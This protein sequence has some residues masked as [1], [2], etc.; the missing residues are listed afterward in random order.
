MTEAPVPTSTG[1]DNYSFKI[2]GKDNKE[3]SVKISKTS[4]N[5]IFNVSCLNSIKSNIYT[6]KITVDELQ[7]LEDCRYFRLFDNVDEIFNE[8]CNGLELPKNTEISIQDQ[9]VNLE[10]KI[11][12]TR[13]REE[14]VI[15][16]L[17]GEEIKI[18]TIVDKLCD[19]MNEVLDLKEKISELMSCFGISEGILNSLI[20]FKKEMVE[21]Y[22]GLKGSTIFRSLYDV[23]IVTNGI[24]SKLSKNTKNFKLLYKASVDGDEAA[25]FHEKC[26][27]HSNT[28]I[29]VQ[30]NTGRRFGGFTTQTWNSTG[31]YKSDSYSF[32]FS[33]DNIEY[34]SCSNTSY[35][36]YCHIWSHFWRWK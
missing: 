30:T 33:I 34:Y 24:S 12:A 4:K 6:T 18:D 27:N 22:S 5:I 13:N 28:V 31:N 32:V 29:I 21:K 25:K 2:T 16:L 14:K 15:L 20:K 19:K 9:K 36:I 10:I 11:K 7:K 26:D 1:G 23:N 3:Y 17:E 35:S 8:L